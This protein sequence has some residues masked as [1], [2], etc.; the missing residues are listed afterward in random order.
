MLIGNS[1]PE[2]VFIRIAVPLFR[3]ITPCAILSCIYVPIFRPRLLAQHKAL[4]PVAVWFSMETLFFTGVYVPLRLWLQRPVTHPSPPPASEREQM[5]G[6]ILKNLPDP[7]Y[8]LSR[9]FMN[10]P[11]ADI[12][13]DNVKEFYAWSLLNK[14][15]QN[16]TNGE[17]DELER[18][19]SQLDEKLISPLRPGRGPA[20]ALRTTFD[21]V[22]MQH[23]PLVWYLVRMP[24]AI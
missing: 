10:A 17:E 2:Y 8:Y 23:R 16:V 12:R 22:P 15:Y 18:Y 11:L 5:Y 9:W 24:P 19:V 14:R 20:E 4:W 6:R 21:P 7:E 13:R 3:L 1:V